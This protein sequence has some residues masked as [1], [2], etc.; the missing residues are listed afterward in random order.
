LIVGLVLA[1][2]GRREVIMVRAG[3]VK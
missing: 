1:L 3:Q 2:G